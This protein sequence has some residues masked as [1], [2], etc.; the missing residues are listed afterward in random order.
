MVAMS[1]IKPDTSHFWCTKEFMAL[2]D[3]PP[4]AK[5]LESGPPVI[6]IDNDVLRYGGYHPGQFGYRR[7]FT[8]EWY[9][10]DRYVRPWLL[11]VCHVA[12]HWVWCRY[13]K[14]LGRTRRMLGMPSRLTGLPA[15]RE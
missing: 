14:S 15:R 8:E 13:H 9:D 3:C 5:L 7:V 4:A 10:A 1:I 2:D 11:W 12:G 6:H